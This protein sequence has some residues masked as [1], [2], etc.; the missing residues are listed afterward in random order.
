M[1]REFNVGGSNMT[2]ANQ[3]VTLAFVRPSASRGIK[4][5]RASVTFAANTTAARIRVQIC[6]YTGNMPTLVSAIPVPFKSA[7]IIT[8]TGGTAGAIGTSG[9]NAS[10][11]NAGGKQIIWE[12]AF[13]AP[14]GWRW[15]ARAGE[16][17]AI[18]QN[19][20]EGVGIFIPAAPV[21]LT[22]WFVNM[23][24]REMGA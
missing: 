9:I 8:I 5:L 17:V 18:A 1:S 6:R 12:D 15:E 16:E 20:A 22:G 13:D 10:N 2:L 21:T 23:V 14:T 19:I 4:L 3:P 24:C 11:E 7:D